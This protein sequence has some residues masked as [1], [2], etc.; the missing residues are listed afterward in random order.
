MTR[1]RVL[2]GHISQANGL[3]GEVLIKSHTANP[4]DI[5]SYGVLGNKDAT[6]TFDIKVIRITTK[7]VVAKIS[8][9]TD[10]TAA[11]VLRGTELYIDR[12][13]LPASDDEDDFYHTDLI[14]LEAQTADGAK[15]GTVIAVQNFGASDL[16][17][18]RPLDSKTTELIPFNKA[19]VPDVDLEG[20]R[21]I[22]VWPD[23]TVKEDEDEKAMREAGE[24]E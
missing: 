23:D 17:E 19:F 6:R 5:G 22:V 9:V 20:G 2:L 10:R 18:I 24:N 14:G 1:Q 13:Q 3:R 8:G 11:E 12:D 7:G 4:A 16:L 21:V 15:V